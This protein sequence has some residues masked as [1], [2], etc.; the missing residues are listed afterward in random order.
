MELGEGVAGG[1]P[2]RGRILHEDCRRQGPA[3]ALAIAACERKDGGDQ[4]WLVLLGESKGKGTRWQVGLIGSCLVNG[5]GKV[6]ARPAVN[7]NQMVILNAN[8]TARADLALCGTVHVDDSAVAV[9]EIDSRAERI[10]CCF[11]RL[12]LFLGPLA[13]DNPP[14]LFCNALHDLQK[15]LVR[16]FTC[17]REELEYRLKLPVCT[18]RQSLAHISAG[19][20]S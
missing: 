15:M 6:Q 1:G 17:S 11:Q 12:L 4:A 10:K 2:H 13:L 3:E 18:R 8:G 14:K 9:G 7:G 16:P 19:F 5:S 20:A